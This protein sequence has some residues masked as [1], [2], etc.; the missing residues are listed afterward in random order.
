[1]F[2]ASGKSLCSRCPQSSPK[3]LE[4]SKNAT[5]IVKYFN[6]SSKFTKDLRDEQKRIYNKYITLIQPGQTRWNSYYFCYQSVLKN[7]RALK[8][9]SNI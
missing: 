1:M 3:L 6:A 2:C 7:K 4:T 5:A 8:V 9:S